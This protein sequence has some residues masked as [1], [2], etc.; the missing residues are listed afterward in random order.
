MRVYKI[1]LLKIQKTTV[2]RVAS[3]SVVVKA[4]NNKPEGRGFETQLG[5]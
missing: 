1:H 2:V 3:G 4:L 5:E